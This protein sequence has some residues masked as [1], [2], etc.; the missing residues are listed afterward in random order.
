MAPPGSISRIQ[1][2]CILGLAIGA[3]G[4]VLALTPPGLAWEENAGLAW[5]F[6]M[7]GPI[8]VPPEVVVVGIDQEAAHELGLDPD[9]SKWPRSTHARLID[10]L[11]RHGA[12]VIVLD[13]LFTQ[14]RSLDEDSALAAA[15]ARAKRVVLLEHI[16]RETV[17]ILMD[18]LVS[19]IPQ[20]SDAAMGLGPF[21]LEKVDAYVNDFW[22]FKDVGG[23][24][25]TLP[26]VAL[27]IHALQVF[28]DFVALLKQAGFRRLDRLPESR[29]D[30]SNAED[31]RELM[32][33]LRLEFR[34]NPQMS[35]RLLSTLEAD[36]GL[37]DW[38]RRLL[39][40]L[41]RLYAGADRPYLNF[42]GPPATIRRI[43]Y[44]A[45]LGDSGRR[46][47]LPG[48]AG[49]VVFVG[50][51]ELASA[52]QEDDFSTVFGREDGVDLSGVEIAATA[53]A[54]LLTD[55]TIRPR[56]ELHLSTLLLFGGLVGTLA[57]LLPGLR[58][59]GVTLAL[60]GIYFFLALLLFIEG[61]LW[62]PVFI[63]LLVQLPA[64]LF[65][66]LFSQYRGA[67]RERES[68]KRAITYYVPEEAVQNV[69]ADGE[70]QV[71]TERVF[72]ACLRTDMVGY[73]TLAEP[74]SPQD[75]GSLMSEY[76]SKLSQPVVR[77][78]GF[79]SDFATD[80]ILCAW[81]AKQPEKDV[82][83]HACLAALEMLE[84]MDLLK[85]PS[86]I[87]LHA[88]W[89]AMGTVGGGGHFEYRVIGDTPNTASR[90][91]GL[92]KH[93]ST[94]ILASEAAAGDLDSFL[95]RRLGSFLLV[96]K[97]KP[98]TIFE[99]MG[100][101]ENASESDQKLCERFDVALNAF[102]AKRW[103]QAAEEYQELLSI[104]PED[105]PA[106]FY[107]KRSQQY[108]EVEP[109][110]DEALIIRIETK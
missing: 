59:V 109:P 24:V 42:Y 61:N 2:A 80:G 34:E 47:D 27:Q 97:S 85:L 16:R 8:E 65:L 44:D 38:K 76:F 104:Y 45:L 43:S 35:I 63:P 40:A 39:T 1:R 69:G 79:V 66:G 105:G 36:R 62:V 19:P 30:L 12:S 108:C 95:L 17:P 53:F 3:V 110:P 29:A 74:K 99:V 91:E 54:N 25:P 14:S 93:L 37:T 20:L 21:P 96:G 106:T 33:L 6:T 84:E 64:A 9:T 57:Y 56:L 82:R 11:V 5:L 107:L 60:G 7:R 78:E 22:A 68:M 13:L 101:R 70:P 92:N 18:R 83:L 55:A 26:A 4:I 81:T 71:A 103:S 77:H 86:R 15:I 58:A 94:R 89:M 10:N 98:V 88:G 23:E 50:A 52:E 32:G 87:G 73:T 28:D 31:V 102:E 75:L 100:L 90:I 72:G 41:V 46:N 48:V 67:K 51:S 49:K